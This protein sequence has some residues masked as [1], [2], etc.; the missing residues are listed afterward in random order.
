MIRPLFLA[1][2]FLAAP[3]VAPLVA[4]EP[5]MSHDNDMAATSLPKNFNEPIKLFPKAL[6]K[7][8]RPISSKNPEA[9]SYFTQGFQLI[10]GKQDAARSFREAE[11][12]DPDCAICFWG[13]AWAWGSYLNGPMQP[14]EAPYAFTAIQKAIKLA[15]GH[16]TP[17]EA[18][19]IDSN[20]GRRTRLHQSLQSFL[21][22]QGQPAVAHQFRDELSAA[23]Q[24]QGL[25]GQTDG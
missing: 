20:D 14:F 10:F 24:R 18:A 25:K 9:Q 22:L 19:L 21:R 2:I 5:P 16:S 17:N 4:Q 6:G 7:F 13:E 3:L 1:L 8:T 15:P 23:G 12:R 11:A